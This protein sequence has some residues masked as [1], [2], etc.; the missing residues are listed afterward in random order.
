[1]VMHMNRNRLFWVKRQNKGNFCSQVLCRFMQML[2]CL[3]TM[4]NNNDIRLS[5]WRRIYKWSV[6]EGTSIRKTNP[7]GQVLLVAITEEKKD[8]GVALTLGFWVWGDR[9][10][11]KLNGPSKVLQGQSNLKRIRSEMAWSKYSAYLGDKLEFFKGF[12]TTIS[13]VDEPKW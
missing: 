7:H 2:L 4:P 8:C 1:M 9:Q 5:H 6:P 12:Q 13:M 11:G 10:V 3:V